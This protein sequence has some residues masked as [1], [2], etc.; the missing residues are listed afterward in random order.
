MLNEFRPL[1]EDMMLIL[2]DRGDGEVIWLESLLPRAF[3]PRNLDTATG[4]TP[5]AD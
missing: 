3:G 5:T 4:E 1:A 2:D